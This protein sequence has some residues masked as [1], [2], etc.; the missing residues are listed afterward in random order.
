MSIDESKIVHDLWLQLLWPNW[1]FSRVH[2]PSYAQSGNTLNRCK[3]ET[4][5]YCRQ[6]SNSVFV[7]TLSDLHGQSS[8]E[9]FFSAT[10][11]TV[12][13]QPPKIM[14]DDFAHYG[15]VAYINWT[16]FQRSQNVERSL[17]DS[18]ACCLFCTPCVIQSQCRRRQEWCQGGT[19]LHETS[20]RT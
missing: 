20:C 8:I 18:R 9:S 10:S 17:C 13:Q 2:R 19:K 16:R 1:K 5:G 7:V 11:C 4:Y 6:L 14:Y 3:I 15:H 12:V